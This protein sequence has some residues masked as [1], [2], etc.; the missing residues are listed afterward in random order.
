MKKK[1]LLTLYLTAFSA[2][3]YAERANSSEREASG[4]TTLESIQP[5]F[6]S[7]TPELVSAVRSDFN[8]ARED[9]IGGF[10]QFVLFGG[11][12]TNKK[13]LARYFFPDGLEKLTA[14]E[15]IPVTDEIGFNDGKQD[16]LA[17]NFNI[18]TVD[19]N[20]KSVIKIAPQQSTIGLGLYWRQSFWKN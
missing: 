5:N 1:L 14:V 12:S 11:K 7:V 20:F 15:A 18:F 13:D 17:Q 9:G 19:H 4:R 2:S 3:L 8:H 10:V 6:T 16:L